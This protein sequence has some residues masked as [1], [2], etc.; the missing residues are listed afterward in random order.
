SGLVPRGSHMTPQVNQVN[1]SEIKQV[2]KQ[3]LAEALYTEESEIAED[4][5]FVDLGLDS[6][7]GVEWTTTIN[8][9]YN[10]NLKATKLYDYPT[11]LELSGYIAQILSSQGT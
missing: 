10:L 3:Q 5:K 9:T 2:L 6:I 11:L 7:V 8:Q 1:L 4:Q